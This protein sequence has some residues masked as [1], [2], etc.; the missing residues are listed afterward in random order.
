MRDSRKI[1][2]RALTI[3][4]WIAAFGFAAASAGAADP[5][6]PK[7]NVLFIA[8]DDMNCDLGCYGNPL[9]KSPNLDRLAARGV[10]FD[11][12]YCQF[13]LC[14]PSRSSLLTGLRPDT[15][16]VFDLQVSLPHRACPT[17]SRCRRCSR[18]NG[19]LR[20]ARR[21]DL[22]LRR[23]R[24]HRHQR[25]GRPGIVGA[26]C[27]TR[28]G[29]DKDG[30]EP[31]DQLHAQARPGLL[32][33]LPPRRGTDEEHTDGKGAADAIKLLEDTPRQ[34][35]L[36]RR[37][38]STGRTAP[39][40][41]R[42]STL[43]CIRWSGSRCR[44][45]S[46]PITSSIV[47]APAL[48]STMPWPYF[49]VT[50]PPGPRVQAAYYAAI[51]FVD[52]QIGRVLDAAR[53]ARAGR[54]YHHRLLER[55]RLSP[56]RA[57]PM[58]EAELL[59]GIGPGAADRRRPATEGQRP[60]MPAD[61]GAVRSSIPRWPSCA[62]SA[63]AAQSGRQ[64]PQ[65]ASWTT[66]KRPGTSRP[67]LRSGTAASPGYSVRTERWRYTEWDDGQKG[68]ALYDYQDRSELEYHNLAN[69]PQHA[70]EARRAEGPGRKR[71]GPTSYRPAA[72]SRP[73]TRGQRKSR[74]RRR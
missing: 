67:S 21:Q 4:L 22:S 53:P 12:A 44:R 8:V 17:W 71:T 42:R 7:Y 20:G 74:E 18:N 39:T 68:T 3:A 31:A 10:R 40:S 62:A 47:P 19:Y 55:P 59:R 57:R 66:P 63:S 1:L 48:A 35:V 24:R 32:A 65:A 58:D 29:R 38:A 37:R 16:Q 2:V 60:G 43:T 26:A 73:Q 23:A 70:D 64:E 72:R 49:G 13:P 28:A 9:V 45:S 6:R 56:R 15:T 41:R 46:R 51:S 25:A 33:E 36:P 50:E 5:P 54:Q 34:A 30:R 61:R 27:S 14:S 11:R 69:D 52:A